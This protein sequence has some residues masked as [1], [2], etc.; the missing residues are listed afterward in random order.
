MMGVIMFIKSPSW[1]IGGILHHTTNQFNSAVICELL[2]DWRN[3]NGKSLLAAVSGRSLAS[4]IMCQNKGWK[5]LSVEHTVLQVLLIADNEKNTRECLFWKGQKAKSVCVMN[6]QIA[7]YFISSPL[8]WSV[9]PAAQKEEGP[10][11]PHTQI[12]CLKERNIIS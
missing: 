2:F 3:M 7:Q 11:P 1:C 10:P 12:I 9:C 6:C 8:L 4:Y 5:D